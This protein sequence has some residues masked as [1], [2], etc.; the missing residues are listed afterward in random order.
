[1]YVED[2]IDTHEVSCKLNLFISKLTGY[3]KM[4]ANF[5]SLQ[6]LGKKL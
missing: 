4:A 1:M 2:F 5:E 3:F 6:I